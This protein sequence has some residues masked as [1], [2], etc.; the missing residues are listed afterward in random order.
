MLSQAAQ[1]PPKLKA[2]ANEDFG[3][4]ISNFSAAAETSWVH[5]G[6]RPIASQ[7][8]SM[9]ENRF[10]AATLKR[11][12]M[13]PS[14]SERG[15][16]CP[17]PRRAHL[18][19]GWR[20]PARS[21]SACPSHAPRGSE[22]GSSH[23]K[24]G[25]QSCR[26]RTRRDHP[27]AQSTSAW[28]LVLP[29]HPS[30]RLRRGS[31]RAPVCVTSGSGSRGTLAA[32]AGA[33]A[34][35]HAAA[36]E[37]SAARR[38]ARPAAEPAECAASGAPLLVSL[39]DAVA[40]ATRRRR[41]RGRARA[42]GGARGRAAMQAGMATSYDV[43]ALASWALQCMQVASQWICMKGN[44]ADLGALCRDVFACIWWGGLGLR[45]IVHAAVVKG[46]NLASLI[47]SRSLPFRSCM[48][49]G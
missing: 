39:R 12:Q 4:S 45:P 14:H 15:L 13:L 19:A 21:R 40:I 41:P 20:G 18:A 28:P 31:M 42:V 32:L 25:A 22:L 30:R 17:S 1:T 23:G 11:A 33:P 44:R 46:P 34:A 27:R 36:E 48:H 38:P 9:R 26:Q 24:G 29:A 7:T 49:G 3:G 2:R 37:S 47:R 5:F 8:K 10:R 6:V 16:L 43:D 35:A